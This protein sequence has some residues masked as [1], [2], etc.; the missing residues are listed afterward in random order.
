MGPRSIRPYG[1]LNFKTQLF[2][3]KKDALIVGIIIPNILK[4][5]F[6]T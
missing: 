3:D 4:V 2:I 1:Q 6:L 5:T